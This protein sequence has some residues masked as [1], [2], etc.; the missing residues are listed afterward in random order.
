MCV[1]WSMP[2]DPPN[3]KR[4]SAIRRNVRLPRRSLCLGKSDGATGCFSRSTRGQNMLFRAGRFRRMKLVEPQRRQ[5]PSLFDFPDTRSI[6]NRPPLPP[7]T[8]GLS[9]SH[10]PPCCANR[11]IEFLPRHG[12]PG[13]GASS[14]HPARRSRTTNQ[15]QLE[16]TT[17]TNVFPSRTVPLPSAKIPKHRAQPFPP[18]STTPPA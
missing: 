18:F 7:K 13:A 16:P 6:R 14:T 11:S 12:P 3:T 17:A 2:F 10:T 5:R 15:H 8:S 1:R 9:A 4:I